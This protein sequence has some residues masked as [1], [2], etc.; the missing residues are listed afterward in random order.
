MTLAGSAHTTNLL[1]ALRLRDAA[2]TAATIKLDQL[3]TQSS[4][5]TKGLQVDVAFVVSNGKEFWIDV[6]RVH[7]TPNTLVREV[8][9]FCSQVRRAEALAG[10]KPIN[11]TMR[12]VSSPNVAMAEDE[13]TKKY[14][15]LIQLVAGQR[16][17]PAHLGAE[18]RDFP[19][20]GV[21]GV[22]NS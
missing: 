12:G 19:D 3:F 9:K 8:S 11:S 18:L 4:S 20:Q 17:S 15:I 21:R 5:S 2:T 22:V 6:S 14:K 13:K 1:A 10:H 7:H 16:L